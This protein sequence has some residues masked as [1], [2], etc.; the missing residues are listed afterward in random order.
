[1]LIFPGAPAER[2]D[3]ERAT[4]EAHARRVDADFVAR[5]DRASRAPRGRPRGRRAARGARASRASA[6]VRRRRRRRASRR[7]RGRPACRA[8]SSGARPAS[9]SAPSVTV[10][11]VVPATT[12]SRA[13]TAR[14]TCRRS[15][16]AVA[17]C[18]RTMRPSLMRAAANDGPT[19]SF[20]PL[21]ARSAP[22]FPGASA[23][24]PR[25]ATRPASGCGTRSRRSGASASSFGRSTESASVSPGLPAAPLA[26]SVPPATARSMSASRRVDARDVAA[27]PAGERHAGE[28]RFLR[29]LDGRAHAPVG[30]ELAGD[31][32]GSVDL[33]GGEIAEARRIEPRHAPLGREGARAVEVDRAAALEL[34]VARR[35][36]EL[37]EGDAP[38][39]ERR[40][41]LELDRPRRV[42]EVDAQ[43]LD[44][45]VRVGDHAAGQRGRHERGVQAREVD[46]LDVERGV[47]GATGGQRNARVR[48]RVRRPR[49]RRC[50][51]ARAP[52][53][54]RRSAPTAHSR[55]RGRRRS[56]RPHGS[57]SPTRAG[58]AACRRRDVDVDVERACAAACGRTRPG[59]GRASRRRASR[60]GTS[61]NGRRVVRAV[62]GAS[63]T[64]ALAS[65]SIAASVPP[66]FAVPVTPAA[67]PSPAK[68]SSPSSASGA[69]AAS[70]ACASM[71]PQSAA[72][73]R[74][75]ST[76]SRA[77]P[78]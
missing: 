58:R 70:F 75:R 24:V 64:R 5:D 19:T 3:R 29:E 7:G 42:R 61:S 8:G 31:L 18:S 49:S 6:R 40:V 37:R 25:S 12:R 10:E 21:N 28:H 17:P 36:R 11:N 72:S 78:S 48:A 53:R 41:G 14:S 74:S 38:R 13:P 27:Q 63:R 60:S 46:A 26:R 43:A 69:V 45:L 15:N 23:T 57:R 52:C 39:G 68:A 55:G 65:T 33:P 73:T 35:G 22:W 44:A 1:M 4:G 20:S 34:R 32:V 9:P 62:T 59:R 71:R 76:C 66:S 30:H 47:E 2:V 51:R 67:S 54:P 50:R 56:S 16:A 77:P